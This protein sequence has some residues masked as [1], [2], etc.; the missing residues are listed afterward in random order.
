MAEGTSR[1]SLNFS[2]FPSRRL[3]INFQVGGN[4]TWRICEGSLLKRNVLKMSSF[5]FL[6]AKTRWNGRCFFC[7]VMQ[8]ESRLALH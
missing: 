4:I 1:W 7:T 6:E 2:L 5:I 8:T 3:P